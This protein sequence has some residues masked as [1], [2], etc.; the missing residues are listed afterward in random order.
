MIRSMT[1]LD[2]TPEQRKKGASVARE[3][4]RGVLANPFLTEEQRLHVHDEMHRLDKWEK[5]QPLP[6]KPSVG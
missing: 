6:P 1:Y 5:G 4:L 3:R 2:L